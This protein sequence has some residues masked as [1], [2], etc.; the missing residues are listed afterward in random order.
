MMLTASIASELD[1]FLERSVDNIRYLPEIST[2]TKP[3][4][5]PSLHPY[6]QLSRKDLGP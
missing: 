3:Q 2:L 5:V 6:L 4:A 1:P